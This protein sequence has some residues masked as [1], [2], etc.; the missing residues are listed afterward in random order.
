MAWWQFSVRCDLAEVAQIEELLFDLGAISIN[1]SDAEDEP[2]YEPLPGHMPLW[3]T[4]IVTGM[5]D[6]AVD[7]EQLF[8][9]I[10]ESLPAHLQIYLRQTQLDDRD[11]VQAYREHYFPIQCANKLWI[12]P[13][14]HQPPD[15]NAINIILDPG[16][17]FGTGGHPTTA[18]CLSWLAENN[19]KDMTVIDYGCGSGILAI[20]ALKL[21]A[22]RVIG[23]DIDP[24]ALEASRRNADRNNIAADRF[25]L[26]LPEQ[27]KMTTVQLVIANILAGPLVKLSE[28]LAALVIPGG[29]ILLSGILDQQTDEIQSAY[30]SFFNL[31]RSGA[32]EGWVRITGTRLHG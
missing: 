7:P 10:N 1:L 17:A 8:Q 4:S 27:F 6:T 12:V 11:W 15:P 32:S 24:Q 28:K 25:L 14:W 20:A 26:Y 9:T 18:L 21:G 19:L 30:R 16:L 29:K 22:K 5:F 2:I 3:Q 13:G 23:V 31:H